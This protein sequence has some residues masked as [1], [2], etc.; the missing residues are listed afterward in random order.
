MKATAQAKGIKHPLL[1][2]K[3]DQSHCILVDLIAMGP[4]SRIP[5]LKI[6][7]RYMLVWK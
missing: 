1:Y 3:M 7:I 5:I 4:L 2:T 6:E